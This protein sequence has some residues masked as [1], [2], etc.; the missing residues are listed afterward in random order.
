MEIAGVQGHTSINKK[1][2]LK[3]RTKVI[4]NFPHE[5]RNEN[6][7][8]KIRNVTNSKKLTR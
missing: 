4:E 3:T 7:N 1:T 5:N 8:N 6:N 2:K